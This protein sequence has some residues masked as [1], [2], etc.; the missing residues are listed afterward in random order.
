MASKFPCLLVFLVVELDDVEAIRALAEHDGKEEIKISSHGA[1]KSVNVFAQNPVFAFGPEGEFALSVGKIEVEFDFIVRFRKDGFIAN[2]VSFVLGE[3]FGKTGFVGAICELKGHEENGPTAAQSQTPVLVVDA[4]VVDVVIVFVVLV[5]IAQWR[6]LLNLDRPSADAASHGRNG[7]QPHV[8]MVGK[9][10]LG[11]R[12][13]R[14]AAVVIEV[15][16]AHPGSTHGVDLMRLQRLLFWCESGRCQS[17]QRGHWERTQE[18]VLGDQVFRLFVT[19]G[20]GLAFGFRQA[21]HF[22][23]LLP[24]GAVQPENNGLG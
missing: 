11:R 20:F 4:V 22:P 12:C 19:F 15:P 23:G 3:S 8:I 17:E 14:E 10:H 21:H 13:E 16:S 6:N 5:V 1:L 7:E 18:N 9:S 2:V 24:D